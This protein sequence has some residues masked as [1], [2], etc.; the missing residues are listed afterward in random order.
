MRLIIYLLLL[1]L[2]HK[3]YLKQETKL[4]KNHM[5]H[6]KN[7]YFNKY[8]NLKMKGVIDCEPLEFKRNTN[9]IRFF[10]VDYLKNEVYNSMIKNNLK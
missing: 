8:Y 10:K 5:V 1:Y 7:N 3:F 4:K 6:A 2:W 9:D